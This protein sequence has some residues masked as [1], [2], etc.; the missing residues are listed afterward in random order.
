MQEVGIRTK[1]ADPSV[2]LDIGWHVM[3]GSTPPD[4]AT[5]ADFPLK[6][7]LAELGRRLTAGSPGEASIAYAA[8][9][10]MPTPSDLRP[11]AQP[12]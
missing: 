2:Q 9:R 6:E 1:Y 7:T 4:F 11:H 5:K 8:A 12:M 3:I 10:R